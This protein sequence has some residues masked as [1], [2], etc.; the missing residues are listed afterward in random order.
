MK[1]FC[2]NSSPIATLLYGENLLR[3]QL[4]RN[5]KQQ[6]DKSRWFTVHP[7][8]FHCGLNGQMGKNNLPYLSVIHSTYLCWSYLLHESARSNTTS[9]RKITRKYVIPSLYPT[10]STSFSFNPLH[11]HNSFPQSPFSPSPTFFSL[12]KLYLVLI[13]YSCFSH[14]AGTMNHTSEKLGEREREREGK[15]MK[16]IQMQWQEQQE[17]DTERVSDGEEREEDIVESYIGSQRC[18]DKRERL[19]DGWMQKESKVVL[20]N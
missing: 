8:F 2:D 14:S 7:F 15:G 19:A 4:N 1:L 12:K 20:V 9:G 13:K 5:C 17:R 18:K 16:W 3:N 6:T 10:H 11:S